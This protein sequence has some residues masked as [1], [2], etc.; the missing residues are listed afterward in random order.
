VVAHFKFLSYD[1]S[2]SVAMPDWGW[3]KSR[4][5]NY[6]D[7][8]GDMYLKIYNDGPAPVN[9][10]HYPG[11]WLL[12]VVSPGSYMAM[13]YAKGVAPGTIFDVNFYIEFQAP[14]SYMFKAE[15]GYYWPDDYISF[16]CPEGEAALNAALRY[17]EVR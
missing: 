2:M 1:A 13:W 5:Q 3:F 6:G 15:I 8:V 12:M 11:G 14:G 16:G 9:I 10:R 17:A 4:V 7:E